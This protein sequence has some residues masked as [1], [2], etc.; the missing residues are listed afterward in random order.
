M[1]HPLFHNGL[2]FVCHLTPFSYFSSFSSADSL[3]EIVGLDISYHGANVLTNYNQGNT[4]VADDN[5]SHDQYVAE[6]HQ[7][8]QQQ[9]EENQKR[10]S[11]RRRMLFLDLSSSKSDHHIPTRQQQGGET[12]IEMEEGANEVF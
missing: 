4:Y 6:H 5:G 3:D 2:V 10:G 12:A 7:R 9:R 8:R 1:M 11:L